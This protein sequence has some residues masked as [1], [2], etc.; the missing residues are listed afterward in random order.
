M[1]FERYTTMERIHFKEVNMLIGLAASADAALIDMLRD[2]SAKEEEVISAAHSVLLREASVALEQISV[3]ELRSSRAGIRVSALAGAGYRN[4]RDLDEADDRSLMS[5][6]GIGEKQ[7]SAIRASVAAFRTQLAGRKTVRLTPDDDSEQN[8]RLIKAV[9]V[10]RKSRMICADAAPVQAEFHQCVEDILPRITIRSSFRWLFSRRNEKE[11]AAAA[12]GDLTR[13]SSS[14]VYERAGNLLGQFRSLDQ[15]TMPE[16]KKDFEQHGAEYY[17]LLE[18][19]LGPSSAPLSSTGSLP[20]DLAAQIDAFRI[21]LDGFFGSLRSYQEFGVKY[22]LHQK[23]VLLGDDMGLGKTIQAIAAMTHLHAQE[24]NGHF[25]VVCPAGVLINWCREIRRFSGLSARLIHGKSMEEEFGLWLEEGGAAVTNYETLNRI[26]DRINDRVRISLLVIDEAHYIKNP[27]ALR[28]RCVRMLEDEASR[29]LLMTGTPLENRVSEMCSLIDFIRPDLAW[30]VRTTSALG[31]TQEFRDLIAP[32]YLRRQRKDV[33]QEL[34]PVEWKEEW[35]SMSEADREAYG[36]QILAGHFTQARRVGFL[37]ADLNTSSKAARLKELCIKAEQAGRKA[38]VYS[39]FRETI[40]K[41]CDHLKNQ[42]AG[43]ITGSTPADD[44]Q[45]IVDSFAD[46]P[47]GS[48]LVCQIQ[49]GGTGLNI[50]SAG[51]VI[52]CEPQIKPSLMHQAVARAWRMGQVHNVQVYTLLCEDTADEAIMKL[53]EEKQLQFDLYA[54]ES[55]IADASEELVDTDWIRAFME[56]EH[57]RYLPAVI[58]IPEEEE[59]QRLTPLIEDHA[60]GRG[61]V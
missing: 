18:K 55:S 16:A 17:I 9:A 21:E 3:E 2:A 35:C 6:N 15:M 59:L 26:A 32:V 19:L 12:I 50:Q 42:V 1:V 54:D 47:D 14:S 22:I 38:I 45:A 11:A 31:C 7:V 60:T 56:E 10:C 41:V 53:L 8:L 5:V 20:V 30:E 61:D 4:L 44:R 29:I 57:N 48:V 43:I 24:K 36:Q 27:R 13:F 40:T 33:R 25:L 37:Q 28:S 34:P 39:Y 58:P 49:A 51:I 52:L 46:A 23:R